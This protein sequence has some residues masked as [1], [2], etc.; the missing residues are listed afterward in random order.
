MTQ[1]GCTSPWGTNKGYICSN[2]TVGLQAHTLY[3]KYFFYKTAS[4]LTECPKPCNTM[5]LRASN[6]KKE[7]QFYING[8]ASARLLFH[9]SDLITVTNE[10]YSYIWLNLLAEAGGY[11]GLILGF[12]VY[13]ITDLLDKF[14]K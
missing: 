5:K 14:M 12:S 4:R 11:V 9:F 7:T 8:L 10:Y 13:Q 6:E 3:K 2:Q 1:F